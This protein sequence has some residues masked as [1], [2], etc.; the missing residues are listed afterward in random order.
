MS[1]ERR[2]KLIS[3]RITNFRSIVDTGWC[4]FSPD[5]ATVI[6]GQNESGKSSI[7]EALGKTFNPINISDDDCRIDA[8][9][10]AFF[11]RAIVDPK[12]LIAALSGF[13]SEQLRALETFIAKKENVLTIGFHWSHTTTKEKYDCDLACED[14][15]LSDLLQ[16]HRPIAHSIREST[17]EDEE[18]EGGN[19][20]EEYED[21]ET[22]AEQKN[23]DL[24]TSEIADAIY[25][26]APST[27]LFDQASGLLPD[28][29]DIEKRNGVWQ[30]AGIGAAAA[31][32]F[33]KIADVDLGSLVQGSSRSQQTTLAR[34]NATVTGDFGLFWSQTIGKREKLQ[35]KCEFANYGADSTKPG[36]P[37]LEF[38]I[39]DGLNQLFP[40][41]HDLLPNVP[42]F[43]SRVCSGFGP[44]WGG[45]QIRSV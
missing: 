21:Q 34:A 12:E 38:W 29:V 11:L 4:S 44:C 18:D 31:A 3:F 41:Q 20:E 19:K 6:V 30:L 27:V 26:L 8:D 23:P 10:P 16:E 43:I 32:N 17:K 37:H 45:L 40:K 25:H 2:M 7:L 14:E 35:L 5:G 1:S 24:T 36:A 42:P 33:L 15:G 39:T 9:L 28:R 13:P 22:K